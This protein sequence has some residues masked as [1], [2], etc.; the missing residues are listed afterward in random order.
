MINQETPNGKKFLM[1]TQT[2]AHR[3]VTEVT[4]PVG[5]APSTESGLHLLALLSVVG[6]L[7][8]HFRKKK[9]V[10]VGGNMFVFYK[11]GHPHARK[12]PDVM[13]AKAVEAK[14][15][16]KSFKVW[17]EKAGPSFILELTSR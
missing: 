1:R 7:R 16:R 13:V 14:E 12:A 2:A 6:S 11:E 8:H 10:F 3:A 15:N 5:D 4:Y 17:Q 9:D